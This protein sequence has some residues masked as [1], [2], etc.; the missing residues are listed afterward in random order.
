MLSCVSWRS[1]SHKHDLIMWNKKRFSAAER[2]IFLA[3]S[4]FVSAATGRRFPASWVI[5]ASAIDLSVYKNSTWCVCVCVCVCEWERGSSCL[6]FILTVYFQGNYQSFTLKKEL[7]F[8]C[9]FLGYCKGERGCVPDSIRLQC[10]MN[11]WYDTWSLLIQGHRDSWIM[12]FNEN[13]RWTKSQ[14]ASVINFKSTHTVQL[15]TVMINSSTGLQAI[16]NVSRK[17]DF[18]ESSWIQ[19]LTAFHG[20]LQNVHNWKSTWGIIRDCRTVICY[21]W[22]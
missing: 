18:S 6:Y 20:I 21:W 5:Y 15:R 4:S 14:S 3:C 7:T 19:G 16:A 8:N 9:M 17:E 11:S 22:W 13:F 12:K 2:K 1:F 10:N